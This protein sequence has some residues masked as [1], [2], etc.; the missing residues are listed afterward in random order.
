MSFYS[1]PWLGYAVLYDSVIVRI[2]KSVFFNC[3]LVSKLWINWYG[4]LCGWVLLGFTPREL[5]D[6]L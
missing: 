2:S 4:I 1:L 3:F 5:N 6:F